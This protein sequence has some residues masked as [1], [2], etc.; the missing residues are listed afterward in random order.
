VLGGQL[1]FDVAAI[2]DI[3]GDGIPNCLITG[4]GIARVVHGNA[5]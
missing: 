5:L 4:N 1:G 3:S 2:G